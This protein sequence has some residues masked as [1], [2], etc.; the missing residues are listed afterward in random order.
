[1]PQ[2]DPKAEGDRR[3][4]SF[5]LRA[6]CLVL[7]IPALL[8]LAWAAFGLQGYQNDPQSKSF[9]TWPAGVGSLVLAAALGWI[10]LR[11]PSTRLQRWVA[12]LAFFVFLVT[13]AG[14][15]A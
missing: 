11:R 6:I 7:V 9:Q 2:S 15:L 1:M 10:C 4:V 3:G 5:W 13:W 8:V 14:V 12:G